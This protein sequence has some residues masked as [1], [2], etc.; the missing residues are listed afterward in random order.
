VEEKIILI[1]DDES[2]SNLM[3]K[4]LLNKMGY[5]VYTAS[6]GMDAYQQ[7]LEISPDIVIT[8]L[9]MPVLCGCGLIKKIRENDKVTP[10]IICTGM[11]VDEVYNLS[12]VRK[13]INLDVLKDRL[14]EATHERYDFD[15]HDVSDFCELMKPSREKVQLVW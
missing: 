14:A 5:T 7:Y 11:N 3:L 8:D 10:I 15:I 13:P 12:V 4:K 1:A 2:L 9:N 6:D